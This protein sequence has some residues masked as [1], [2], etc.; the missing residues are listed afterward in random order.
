MLFSNFSRGGCCELLLGLLFSQA[1]KKVSV[2]VI[3]LLLFAGVI[4]AKLRSL[5]VEFSRKSR[6]Q[7]KPSGSQGGKKKPWRFM[8]SLMFLRDCVTP[9]GTTSNLNLSTSSTS[10]ITTVS[11]DGQLH[12]DVS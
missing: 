2:P 10:V 9:R 7:N 11:E 4:Q 3:D 5:R 12:H 8:N 6:E 1:F